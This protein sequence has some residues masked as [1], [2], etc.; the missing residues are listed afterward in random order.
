MLLHLIPVVGLLL[1]FI[2]DHYENG[3]HTILKVDKKTEYFFSK[4]IAATIIN[5]LSILI[6][7]LPF[8]IFSSLENTDPKLLKLFLEIVVCLI[9]E[10]ILLIIISIIIALL[11]STMISISLV[12]INMGFAMAT[13]FPYII[14]QSSLAYKQKILGGNMM[15]YESLR[16]L[17]LVLF[18]TIIIAY[19]YFYRYN[20]Y[21]DEK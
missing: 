6:F 20:Y 11:T 13:N 12:L 4:L 14:G 19:I 8:F 3:I 7:A 15:F 18:F 17:L 1:I 9:L 5:M 16:F 10:N 2:K 21:G